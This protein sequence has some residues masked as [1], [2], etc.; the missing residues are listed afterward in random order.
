MCVVQGASQIVTCSLLKT[1]VDS[2]RP[3]QAHIGETRS[4][5]GNGVVKDKETLKKKHYP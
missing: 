4:A 2:F 3:G 5:W 1:D